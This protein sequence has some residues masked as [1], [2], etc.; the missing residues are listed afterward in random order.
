MVWQDICLSVALD[1]V[2]RAER[3]KLL[4]HVCVIDIPIDDIADDVVRMEPMT[5]LIGA[6]C[7]IESI[8][9]FE[10]LHSLFRTNP[11]AFCSGFQNCFDAPHT[12]C[13]LRTDLIAPTFAALS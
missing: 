1:A 5:N 13:S 4:A 6:G 9:P 2:K 10:Q 12:N 3:A 7:E 8:R 11:A